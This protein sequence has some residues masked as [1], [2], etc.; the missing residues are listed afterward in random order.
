[1]K[2]EL[3]TKMHSEFS[4]D[5]KTEIKHKVGSVLEVAIK[6]NKTSVKDVTEIANRYGLKY[7]DIQEWRNYWSKLGLRI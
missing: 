5:K 7:D 6:M 4:V 1:M 3:T 2:E